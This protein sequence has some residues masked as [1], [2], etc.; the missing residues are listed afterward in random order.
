MPMLTNITYVYEVNIKT[1]ATNF[2]P[3]SECLTQ[4]NCL[5]VIR[6]PEASQ[7]SCLNF[8]IFEMAAKV[9]SVNELLSLKVYV[10]KM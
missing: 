4:T 2:N 9:Y 8:A 10:T 3:I 6:K 1:I 5:K 7:H